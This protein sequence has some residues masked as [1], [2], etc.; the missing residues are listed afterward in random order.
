MQGERDLLVY[1]MHIGFAQIERLPSSDFWS[2]LHS[3][4]VLYLNG[5]AVNSRGCL[6]SLNTCPQLHVLTLYD[7][8]LVLM[9]NYRHH[10]VNR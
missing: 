7:T 2:T 5:N 4:R 9:R 8:P 1:H 10:V 3:L 6:A